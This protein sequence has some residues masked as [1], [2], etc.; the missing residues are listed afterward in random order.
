MRQLVFYPLVDA[1]G[2]AAFDR[3]V[4]WRRGPQSSGKLFPDTYFDFIF[5]GL[6][7][8]PEQEIQR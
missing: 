1:V 2:L 4:A 7:V 5:R 3:P 6:L 8:A